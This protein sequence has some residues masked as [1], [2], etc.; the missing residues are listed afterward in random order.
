MLGGVRLK[1]QWRLRALLCLVSAIALSGGSVFGAQEAN[2]SAPPTEYQVKAAFLFQ[3]LLYVDWP[4]DAAEKEGKSASLVIGVL[5]KDPFGLDLENAVKDKTVGNNPV[6]IKRFRKLD[7]VEGCHILFV[8][9]SEKSRYDDIV[10][11]CGGKPILTVGDE[12]GF[13]A[14]GGAMNFILA[15][16]RVR[17]EA[18]VDA[19]KNDGLKVSSKLLSLA[20]I[21]GEQSRKGAK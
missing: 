17:F 11:K 3:F 10:A 8:A 12:T 21:V 16:N 7:E 18:N 6:Q 4:K 20:K 9:S 19:I 13:T 5:G 1:A 14:A 15:D 2:E